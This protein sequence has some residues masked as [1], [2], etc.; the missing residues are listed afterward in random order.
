MLLLPICLGALLVVTYLFMENLMLEWGSIFPRDD[1]LDFSSKKRRWIRG[2]SIAIISND[3][4]GLYSHLYATA[5]CL[6]IRTPVRSLESE[7]RKDQLLKFFYSKNRFKSENFAL[8]LHW[9]ALNEM[10]IG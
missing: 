2:P 9:K 1:V 10:N 6:N 3:H 8:C 7:F 4:T 5:A